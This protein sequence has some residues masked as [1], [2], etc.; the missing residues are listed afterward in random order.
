MPLKT[1]RPLTETQRY[2]QTLDFSE[3]TT[4]EPYKPLTF[5]QREKAGRN[6]RGIITMRRRGSGHKRLLRLVDFKRARPGI[7][8]VVETIEYDPNRSAN[9]ALIR[10]IDGQRAYII[11]PDTVKVGQILVNKED[12]ALEPGNV[13]PLGKL[14]LN[15][16]VHNVELKPGRG[17]Q[18]AR[19]AGTQCEIV[20]REG[21]MVHL[22]L[23]SGEIRMIRSEC[24]AVIGR[25]G[26]VDYNK[27]VSGSAGRSRWLGKRPKVRGV[28]MNPIDHPMGGGEG[29]TSGGGHPVSPWGKKAKGKKTR[30]NKRTDKF[31]VKHRPKNK[32]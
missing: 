4:N 12:A 29:K 21:D 13:L 16:F 20:A 19:A 24:K 18:L 5:G 6:N 22:K 28:A 9:I 26:N 10:Y 27:I 11:A 25:V 32:A 30:N 17:G 23:P 15:T 3:I 8:A 14:P 31:I 7:N 2:K 1:Y